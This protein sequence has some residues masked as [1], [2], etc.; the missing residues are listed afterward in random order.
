MHNNGVGF[1]YEIF[2][3][4][5]LVGKQVLQKVAGRVYQIDGKQQNEQLSGGRGTR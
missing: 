5:C 3:F 2:K 4:K 1:Y